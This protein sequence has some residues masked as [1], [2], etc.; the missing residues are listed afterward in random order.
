MFNK[1]ELNFLYNIV[2]EICILIENINNIDNN[3]YRKYLIIVIFII[4]LKY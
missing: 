4:K 2:I 3:I 1:L